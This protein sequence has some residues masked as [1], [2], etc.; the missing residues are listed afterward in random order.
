M[1]TGPKQLLKNP[2]GE[3]RTTPPQPFRPRNFLERLLAPPAACTSGQGKGRRR[4]QKGKATYLPT[5]LFLRFLRFFS[6]GVLGIPMQRNGQKRDKKSRWEKTTGKK[7][8]FF[9]QLFRP[10]VFDMDSP[11]KKIGVFELPLL[12]NAQKRH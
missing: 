9:S 4:K 1:Q 8:F 7:F 12:K 11:P 3:S 10:K 2:L 6:H 5:C